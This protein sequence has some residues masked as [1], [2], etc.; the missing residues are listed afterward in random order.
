VFGCIEGAELAPLRTRN[1]STL[2]ALPVEDEWPWLVRG[3]FSLPADW[4]QGTYRTQVIHF[5]ASLKDEPHDRSCWDAWLGKFE[6]VL[7][8]LHWWSATLNLRTEFEPERVFRWVPSQTAIDAMVGNPPHCV[9][10]WTRSVVVLESG[11]P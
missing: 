1:A 4:P 7:R 2:A 6:A 9:Q 11:R 10:E 8:R 5:G 3:M